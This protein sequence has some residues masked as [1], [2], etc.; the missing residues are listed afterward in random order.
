M[1]LTDEAVEIL[2]Q[3]LSKN[4]SL[5]TLKLI[6]NKIR[7]EG[8][9]ALAKA[10]QDNNSLVELYLT[11]NKIGDEG[12]EALAQALHHNDTIERLDL[13]SNQVKSEGAKNLAQA[14]QS[15]N[16]L[17][18]LGLTNNEITDEGG[19][20]L[21]QALKDNTTLLELSINNISQEVQ[22]KIWTL[23]QRN[24]SSQ[25]ASNL[26][27]VEA[28]VAA[29]SDISAHDKTDLQHMMQDALE[30]NQSRL[31]KQK[32]I[33]VDADPTASVADDSQLFENLLQQVAE[34]TEGHE[35]KIQLLMKMYKTQKENLKE[36]Q[37]KTDQKLEELT[38]FMKAHK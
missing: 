4:K 24:A 21:F 30:M 9:K 34:K 20:A 33:G 14:I 31:I 11:D 1:Q 35:Q 28:T 37:K 6:D 17:Q 8:A 18:L 7:D 5:R 32:T 38:A 13:S 27:Q 15:N 36:Y 23:L 22:E 3:S 12:A 19:E 10:L 2:A 29:A 26:K 16:S 25:L